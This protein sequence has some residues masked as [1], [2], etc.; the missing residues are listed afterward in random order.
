MAL[1]RPDQ[2]GPAEAAVDIMPEL[3]VPELLVK[4]IPE[5]LAPEVASNAL[6][7]GVGLAVQVVQ[8]IVLLKDLGMVA[9]V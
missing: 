3:L 4:E 1:A 9:Q 8:A 5:V 7:V 2:A 6:E